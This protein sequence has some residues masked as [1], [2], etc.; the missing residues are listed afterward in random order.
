[1]C[2]D[3]NKREDTDMAIPK[4]RV[5]R[6]FSDFKKKVKAKNKGLSAEKQPSKKY[7][8]ELNETADLLYADQVNSMD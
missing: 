1:M 7:L 6:D 8:N 3:Y 4:E 2:D 5:K